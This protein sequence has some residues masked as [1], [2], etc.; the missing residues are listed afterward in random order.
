MKIISLISVVAWFIWKTRCDAIFRNT[1]PNFFVIVGKTFAHVQDYIT[2]RLD[3]L[4]QRLI[5][6]NFNSFDGHFLF[7]HASFNQG[8]KVSTTGFFISKSDYNIPL[9]GC[10]SQPSDPNSMHT[11]LALK[12]A[13]HATIAH[14]IT[15]QHIFIEDLTTVNNIVNPD[16]ILTRIYPKLIS[17]IQNLLS[18]H[19]HPHLHAILRSWMVPAK[20]LSILGFNYSTLNLFLFG[21]ELPY[22]VMK[23]FNE[24]SFVF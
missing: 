15:I 14:R 3:L 2:S 7:I 22:W 8:T 17:S 6:N 11:L 21:Q 10:Y 5:L 19:G 4:G 9:A 12:V 1:K 23:S 24:S 18:M 16:P 13:L 20:K